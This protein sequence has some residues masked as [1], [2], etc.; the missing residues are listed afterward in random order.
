M[1]PYIQGNFQPCKKKGE[2][3]WFRRQH[4][5]YDLEDGLGSVAQNC[6]KCR[7]TP[8]TLSTSYELIS[9]VD[10]T[11]SVWVACAY[12]C[13]HV[14]GWEWYHNWSRDWWSGQTQRAMQKKK[15]KIKWKNHRKYC[16]RPAAWVVPV[17]SLSQSNCAWCQ[18]P[19]IHNNPV[20]TGDKF[21]LH[22]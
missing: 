5:D 8:C 17:N 3:M 2:M 1:H 14:S 21:T 15:N 13:L 20:T 9:P 7:F 6:Q 18:L 4:I 16:T 10:I 19:P 11:C 12:P 22:L